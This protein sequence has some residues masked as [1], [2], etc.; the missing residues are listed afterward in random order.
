MHTKDYQI[1]IFFL[2]NFF[3]SH[4]FHMHVIYSNRKR[5]LWTF[6]RNFMKISHWCNWSKSTKLGCRAEGILMALKMGPLNISYICKQER[7]IPVAVPLD[8][9]LC[10]LQ[11]R[12]QL[13]K[14]WIKLTTR[15][16][17]I[18]W[19][20]VDKTDCTIHW[21]MIYPLESIIQSLINW[22]QP[23]ISGKPNN[24]Y[25]NSVLTNNN[26]NW[27]LIRW[28]PYKYKTLKKLIL[29]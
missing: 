16:I 27:H 8:S 7:L 21:I 13:F 19:I 17:S 3:N 1:Y 28:Y 29:L 5:P 4:I 26:Q 12:D 18:H 25:I 6:L 22:R 10:R 15:E 23:A 14:G 24:C 11:N 2:I 9:S 20:N